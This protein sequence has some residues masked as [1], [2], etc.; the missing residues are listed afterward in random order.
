MGK[1]S[2]DQYV[3]EPCDDQGSSTSSSWSVQILGTW[4]ST[5][6]PGN[7][8]SPRGLRWH[9]NRLVV[10]DRENHRVQ[11]LDEDNQYEAEIR[12]DSQFPNHFQPWDVAIS[13]DD[14]YY[15]TDIGNNQIIVCYQNCEIIQVI[16]LTVKVYGITIMAGFVWVTDCQE[17]SILKYT[18]SGK[19]VA[20]AKLKGHDRVDGIAQYPY[21][22]VSTVSNRLLV[23]DEYNNI[24][25]VLDSDMNYLDSYC[26]E[27][28]RDGEVRLPRG[29][30]LDSHGNIYIC[31][32]RN[33]RILKLREN[34]E[35]ICNLFEGEIASP[36][37]I[38]VNG[39]GDRIAITVGRS[40]S[41][42]ENQIFLFSK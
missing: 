38:A 22:I 34:G 3:W 15:I 6:E 16:N 24:I 30:D 8:N 1:R 5:R 37:H 40:V 17:Y 29:I 19:F 7:F 9:R 20:K 35:F 13:D 32:W 12:F 41:A 21:S 23:S 18:L 36:N 33:H 4:S 25:Q 42:S 10:C 2:C 14:K 27:G 26:T 11:I 39:N 28:S 31:D